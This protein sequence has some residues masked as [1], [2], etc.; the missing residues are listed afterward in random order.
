MTFLAGNA[1]VLEV[2]VADALPEAA[3]LLASAVFE[4]FALFVAIAPESLTA[5][6][7]EPPLAPQATRVS[8]DNTASR[9]LHFFN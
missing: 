4:L 3:V 2:L 7:S 9:I 6:G 8:A 5:V 1:V